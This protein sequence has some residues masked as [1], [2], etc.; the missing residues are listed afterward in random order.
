MDTL[1]YLTGFVLVMGTLML[2]WFLTSFI[3][4]IFQKIEANRPTTESNNPTAIDPSNPHLLV[5]AAAVA[6]IMKHEAHKMLS[7]K[8]SGK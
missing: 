7:V 1:P 3:G 4:M 8:E 5:I 6:H 2:L